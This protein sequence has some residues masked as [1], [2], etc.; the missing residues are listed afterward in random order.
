MATW[1]QRVEVTHLEGVFVDE[2]SQSTLHLLGFAEE[3][4][5]L[6]QE[7]VTLTPPPPGPD[8]ELV[9]PDQLTLLLEVHLQGGAKT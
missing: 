8:G 3:N 1:T 6:E 5:L 4:K 2:D 7:D 9:L